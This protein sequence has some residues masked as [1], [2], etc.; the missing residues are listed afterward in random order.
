MEFVKLRLFDGNFKYVMKK[1]IYS[2][3]VGTLP[4]DL[5]IEIQSHLNIKYPTDSRDVSKRTFTAVKVLPGRDL[6]VLDMSES[7][8]LEA[9]KNP[10]VL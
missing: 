7:Q 4:R 10:M 3:A 8:L 6:F 2:L 5:C 9:I 1:D